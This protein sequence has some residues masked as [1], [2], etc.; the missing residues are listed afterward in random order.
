MKLEPGKYYHHSEGRSIYVA[1]MVKTFKFG[2]MM[3][4]EETDSTGHSI[5]CVEAD[6]AIDEHHRWTEIGK[7]EWMMRFKGRMAS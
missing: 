7:D 6:N 2:L 1:G 5:S 4:I 3:V